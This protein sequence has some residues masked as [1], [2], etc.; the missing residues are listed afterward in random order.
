MS[1]LILVTGGSRSGKSAHAQGMAEGLPD[2]RAFV[3][4]CP[5]IDGELD[6]RIDAHRQARAGKG[7]TTIE[8]ASD[9]AAAIRTAND[10]PVLLVD[11]LTLW[12]N[13]LLYDAEKQQQPLTEDAVSEHCRE[14]VSACRAH[15]GTIILVTNEVG[16]GIVPENAS[17]RRFRDLAG[18]ANQEIAR[19]CD[20][21]ILVVCGQSLVMKPSSPTTR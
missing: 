5:T 9:T 11:C 17:A 18:R 20:E 3:A 16:M 1:R 13:N 21:V 7:W 14:L 15:G 6:L 19:E 10:H 2:S 8:A 4:T 12:V